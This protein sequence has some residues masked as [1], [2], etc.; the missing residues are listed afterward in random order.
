[1]RLMEEALEKLAVAEASSED[2]L[3]ALLERAGPRIKPHTE[4]LLVGTRARSVAE[5]G[6]DGALPT[7]PHY[8]ASA[9]RIR[10]IH[11]AKPDFSVYFQVK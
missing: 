6:G 2:R 7:D 1:M 4:V 11:P 9:S 8:S 10:V 3:P 5:I